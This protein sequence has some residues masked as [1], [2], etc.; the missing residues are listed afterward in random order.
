[1]GKHKIHAGKTPPCPNHGCPML[2]TGDRRRYQCPISQALFDV[3]VDES[4]GQIIK[5]K[6]GNTMTT[7]IITGTE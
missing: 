3:E 4:K 6:W 5:D 2:K 7:Y 1:M